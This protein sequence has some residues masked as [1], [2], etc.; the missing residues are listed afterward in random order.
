MRF[1][2][3]DV[4]SPNTPARNHDGPTTPPPN[5]DRESYRQFMTTQLDACFAFFLLVF[6]GGGVYALDAMRRKG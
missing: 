4:C 6:I 1:T 5:I 3:F 2:G